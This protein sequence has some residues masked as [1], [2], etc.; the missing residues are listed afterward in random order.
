MIDFLK[1]S[2]GESPM[3]AI[4]GMCAKDIIKIKN[5]LDTYDI[6]IDELLEC[7]DKN[8]LNALKVIKIEKEIL[9]LSKELCF[10]QDDK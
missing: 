8:K 3:L 7:F 6:N 9:S 5:A 4:L 2:N 1:V 10:L